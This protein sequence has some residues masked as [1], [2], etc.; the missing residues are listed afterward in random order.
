MLMCLPIAIIMEQIA[1]LLH[2]VPMA[3]LFQIMHHA[4]SNNNNNKI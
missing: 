2:V 1:R 4:R 3:S